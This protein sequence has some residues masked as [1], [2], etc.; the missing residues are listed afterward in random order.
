MTGT[1]EPKPG[2]DQFDRLYGE[3]LATGHGFGWEPWLNQRQQRTC[4]DCGDQLYSEQPAAGRSESYHLDDG[5]AICSSRLAANARRTR[6]GRP[7]VGHRDLAEI[8][9]EIGSKWPE[10]YFGARP[11]I[12]AMRTLHSMGDRYLQEDADG[13]VR[14]FLSNAR[15]WRGEDAKR[16]KAELRGMLER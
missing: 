16:V 9:R 12:A 5:T 13:I 11:Y 1:P 7:W 8:A 3:Y 14:Y 4:A 6:Q 10:P 2:S 15:G